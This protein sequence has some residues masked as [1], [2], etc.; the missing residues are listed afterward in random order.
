MFQV[1]LTVLSWVRCNKKLDEK[2]HKNTLQLKGV[3]PLRCFPDFAVKSCIPNII[4]HLY[5][6]QRML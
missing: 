5:I 6:N 4:N 1:F 2:T 3:Y